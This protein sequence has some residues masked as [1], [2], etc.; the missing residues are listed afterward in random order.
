MATLTKGTSY[1]RTGSSGL[2]WA[3]SMVLAEDG[4]FSLNRLHNDKGYS[5]TDGRTV[6]AEPAADLARSRSVGSVTS[7]VSVVAP[8]PRHK[9]SFSVFKWLKK[10]L[11]KM[12]R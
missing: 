7:S 2:I 12:R 6:E 10:A 5:R 4:I 9:S 1:R 3:D 11:I 8:T